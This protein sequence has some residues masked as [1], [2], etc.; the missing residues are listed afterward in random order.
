VTLEPLKASHG[1]TWRTLTEELRDRPI[2][3][4]DVAADLEEVQRNQ[5][6]TPTTVWPS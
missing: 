1:A 5:S 2:G 4:V 3:D 6:E